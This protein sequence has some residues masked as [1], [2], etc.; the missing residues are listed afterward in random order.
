[1]PTTGA[2]GRREPARKRGPIEQ[3]TWLELR[4]TGA[5]RVQSAKGRIALQLS[6]Q[7]DE[8]AGSVTD[9]VTRELVKLLDELTSANAPAALRT[10]KDAREA[11]PRGLAI[12]SA[13]VRH[14]A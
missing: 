11:A 1:M 7:L 14:P 3:A 6:R 8:G 5:G 12:V 4:A 2:R 10:E 9:R 13:P